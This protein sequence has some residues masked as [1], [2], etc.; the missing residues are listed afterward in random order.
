VCGCNAILEFGRYPFE[1]H[2]REFVA[3]AS[4]YLHTLKF[5]IL[6]CE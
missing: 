2:K 1:T 6:F 4:L 3:A 5:I